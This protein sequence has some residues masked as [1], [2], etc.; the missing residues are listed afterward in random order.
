MSKIQESFEAI[1]AIKHPSLSLTKNNGLEDMVYGS[2][3]TDNLYQGYEIAYN[4]LSDEIECVMKDN[5]SLDEENEK[6]RI[7]NASLKKDV[8]RYRWLHQRWQL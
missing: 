3:L 8:E 1:L 7:E 5:K 6:L 2:T 4:E